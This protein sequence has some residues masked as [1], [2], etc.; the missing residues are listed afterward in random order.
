MVGTS[1]VKVWAGNT[2]IVNQSTNLPATATTPFI[3][4]ETRNSA[5]EQLLVKRFHIVAWD[6]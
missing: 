2:L 4:V 5:S 6:Q 1:Q 3:Q